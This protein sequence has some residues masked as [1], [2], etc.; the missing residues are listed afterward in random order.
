MSSSGLDFPD[1]AAV[2]ARFAALTAMSSSLGGA[3]VLFT[4][5][6]RDGI[7]LATASNIAGAASLGLES[8]VTRAK[9]A[10]RGGVCDF[11][12]NSLDEALRILKNEIR[13]GLPVSVILTGEVS[14]H[15]AEIVTRGVQPEIIAFAAPALINRGARL[16]AISEENTQEPV[17]WS[18]AS[19][20]MRWLPVVDTLAIRSLEDADARIRWIEGSPR[21]LGRAFAGQR[22]VRMSGAELEAF[23]EALR[24][25]VKT[26][27][28]PAA[29]SIS[30]GGKL[31]SIS[32]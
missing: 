8:D 3:L 19:E 6:D 1:I 4:G 9:N 5:L 24:S 31:I 12:V 16:L 28:I 18:V 22:F 20:P 29:I 15:I 10:L 23:I 27:A 7:A 17:Q 32:P 13:K 30:R 21:Y 14:A 11:V 26:G 2:Y 25:A